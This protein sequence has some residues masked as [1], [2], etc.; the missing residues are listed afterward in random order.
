[1][2]LQTMPVSWRQHSFRAMGCQMTV[3]LEM[4]EAE[5]AEPLLLGAEAMFAAAERVLSRFDPFSELSRLNHNPGRWMPI[6]ALLWAVVAQAIEMADET[7]GLF[8][9]TQLNALL[10][11]GYYRSFDQLSG[12]PLP[13]TLPEPAGLAGQWQ[14]VELDAQAQ[15]V[16]LP[17]GVGLD[18]GGLAKGYTAQQ[19]VEFL[20]EAGPCLVDAG[21]DISA[22]TAPTGWPGW[23]V[24]LAGPGSASD[25][26]EL[27]SCWLADGTMATSGIDY[28]RWM[29]GGQELHHV[30]DPRT[31][32]AAA[33]DLLTA[34]VLARSAA[35]A[36]AWATAAL[37]AG[38]AS[39]D[40]L[41]TNK[42]LAAAFVDRQYQLHLTPGLALM[43]VSV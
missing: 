31:G 16:W 14:A 36:E 34:T 26:P 43:S 1:M 41:L 42:R 6:S 18:L 15:A 21:G 10:T 12:E 4:A 2:A 7:G 13:M 20:S 38:L 37:V 28:R 33:T 32:R 35:R 23:P 11:A 27:L 3:W 9:P 5:A 24:G 40:H 8:D 25:S 30:M 39:A 29:Q 22:G 17:P 19:V